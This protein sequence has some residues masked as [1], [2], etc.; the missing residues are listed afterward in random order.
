MWIITGVLL[1]MFCL[2]AILGFHPGPH[3]HG[4]A[5]VLGVLVSGWLVYV[6]IERGSGPG[7]WSILGADLLVA[8]G[9]GALA[10]K[11]IS[12]YRHEVA[13][14]HRHPL[15]GAEGVAVSDL[16]PGGIIRIRGEEWSAISVNGTA[17]QGQSGAG[18][19][20]GRG[21]AGGLERRGRAALERRAVHPRR[22]GERG[23]LM[24]VVEV[25]DRR[26][27]GVTP[28]GPWP[29]GQDRPRVPTDRACSVWGVRSGSRAR[30]WF[31]QSRHRPDVAGRPPGAVPRNPSADRHHA[32]QR[33]H[34]HR[35]H[36]L[37]QGRRPRPCPCSRCRTSLWPRKT[38]R[39]RRCGVW[40]VTWSSTTCCR[41]GRR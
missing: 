38:S 24:V 29:L 12:E 32:G 41:S 16:A 7:L 17:R 9:L 20:G 40:S 33:I 19:A 13:A 6:L 37:L 23:S 28:G 11:G 25:L 35:L 15:E 5:G 36:H 26:G 3:A 1:G 39:R 10:W 22:S 34:L 27:G 18:P 2:A 31:H 4:V 30:G 14:E 21:P 8:A